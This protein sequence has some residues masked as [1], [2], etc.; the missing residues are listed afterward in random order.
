MSNVT[1]VIRPRTGLRKGSKTSRADAIAKVVAIASAR[2]R[3]HRFAQ[4]RRRGQK[5][6]TKLTRTAGDR[7]VLREARRTATAASRAAQRAQ[8]LGVNAA[9]SDR[10]VSRDLRRTKR[11]ATRAARLAVRPRSH[12]AR[13]AALIVAGTGALAGAAYAGTRKSE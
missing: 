7:R 12:R 11:H 5:M 10:R 9:L 1:H 4:A 8:K 6:A 2:R 3:A 13:T